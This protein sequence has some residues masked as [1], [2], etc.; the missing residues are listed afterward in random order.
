MS[1]LQQLY[2]KTTCSLH[3]KRC[4]SRSCK[5]LR[6]S[7]LCFTR[8]LP[9]G[10]IPLPTAWQRQRQRG[11]SASS[12]SLQGEHING[13]GCC[14]QARFLNSVFAHQILSISCRVCS[15]ARRSSR[16]RRTVAEAR[17]AETGQAKPPQSKAFTRTLCMT[18]SSVRSINTKALHN[19]V[20]WCRQR[21]RRTSRQARQ[22]RCLTRRWTTNRP[23]G[24]RVGAWCLR[25]KDIF[26]P[27]LTPRQVCCWLWRFRFPRRH[28]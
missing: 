17:E 10:C 6:I 12:N 22:T 7:L 2:L 26:R 9:Q 18:W 28:K 23:T 16:T 1:P 15:S 20:C 27:T 8:Y 19:W 25:V 14:G 3:S 5:G 21:R 13:S 11:Q 24:M 4:A